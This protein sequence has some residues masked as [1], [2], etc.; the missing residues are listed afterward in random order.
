MRKFLIVL[1]LIIISCKGQEFALEIIKSSKFELLKSENQNGLLI[2]FPCYP[3]N[4]EETLNEF[5]IAEVAARNGVSVLAMNFNHH[6]YLRPNEKQE[7][8]EHLTKIIKENSLSEKNVFIGG[9][10]SGGNIALTISDYLIEKKNK[11]QPNGVFVVDSPVDLL[12]LYKTAEKNIKINFSESSVQESQWIKEMF[13]NNFG[14]PA[15]GIDKYEMNS[16]FTFETQNIENLKNLKNT[17]I[18]FYTEP[19]LNW[20][21][22]YARNNDTD[23]NAFYIEKLANQLKI[24]FGSDNIELIKTENKGYRANGQKHPHSW[25]IVNANNLIKWMMK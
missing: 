4:T 5:K 7:L 17:K 14:N 16:P 22:E 1:V 18:R 10:S 19:D 8:A 6:L 11:I 20:W 3:C 25:S 24:E 23:L 13:D 2:L 21:Y 12:G 15:K 9:F